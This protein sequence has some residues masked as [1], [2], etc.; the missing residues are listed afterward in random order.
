[1]LTS[2]WIRCRLTGE[3]FGA[4]DFRLLTAELA[5]L[6]VIGEGTLVPL[7][8]KAPPQ[9]AFWLGTNWV[10]GTYLPDPGF[11]LGN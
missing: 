9:L 7:I 5:L 8:G 2:D 3:Y 11:F 4:A 10:F 6:A 1:M